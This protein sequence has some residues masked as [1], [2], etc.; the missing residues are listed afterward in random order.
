[1]VKTIKDI[2]AKVVKDSISPDKIRLSTLELYYPRMVHAEFM[3]HRVFSR[4]AS[5]SRATPVKT[6]L[7]K[8]M[9]EMYIPRFRYNK[10]GMQP[11]AYLTAEDQTTAEAE[12]MLMAE[13]CAEGVEVLSKIGERGVHKQWA[14]RPLEWFGWIKVLVSA[15]EF[16]NYF[17]LRCDVDSDGFPIA[18][19]EIKYLA[20][21]MR[22]AIDNS[23]PQLLQPGQWHLP[24][25]SDEE[26]EN[27]LVR[28]NGNWEG[29]V[30]ASAS[31]CA[32]VSYLNLDNTKPT[33]E[34]DAETYQ[35][36]AGS[37]PIHASPMEHQATPDECDVDF[38]G[39]TQWVAPELHGNYFGWIQGRKLI[40]GEY[41]PG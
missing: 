14:N 25:V 28:T 36:L 12:W 2:Q 33:R 8:S 39:S 7:A 40:G 31:R 11:G 4:N 38:H 23:R 20:D 15:T 1:M 6:L 21:R 37:R 19:D 32:R 16:M 24:Y 30:R 35:K 13:T 9:D 3:T 29:I 5:S 17:A 18:Q 10:P 26:E 27:E 34:K 22:E 41:V